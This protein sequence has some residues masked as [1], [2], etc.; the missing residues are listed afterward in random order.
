V[1]VLA[2][3][4][5]VGPASLSAAAPLPLAHSARPMIM[6]SD[7]PSSCS[8]PRSARFSNSSC[9]TASCP[10]TAAHDSGAWGTIF[11]RLL[12]IADRPRSGVSFTGRASPVKRQGT[13][14]GGT[15]HRGAIG[16]YQQSAQ[17]GE[18]HKY[19]VRSKQVYIGW[20]EAI[21]LLSTYP[22]KRGHLYT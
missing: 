12:D 19:V 10:H 16:H 11:Q 4:V 3:H 7:R 21:T 22:R 14:K 15:G 9:T 5:E 20:L 18:H 1:L 8:A 13:T 17:H 2:V 6:P